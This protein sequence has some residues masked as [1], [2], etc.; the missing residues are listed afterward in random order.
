LA[1]GELKPARAQ[2]QPPFLPPIR[3]RRESDPRIDG[4]RAAQDSLQ[5]GWQIRAQR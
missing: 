4:N 5:Q 2:G 3:S 1:V